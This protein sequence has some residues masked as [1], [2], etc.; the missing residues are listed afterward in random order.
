MSWKKWILVLVAVVLV[1]AWAAVVV[2]HALGVGK[3]AWIALV[4]M[5]AVVT[6]GAFWVVAAVL[7]T[8]VYQARRR[9]LAWAIARLR[10]GS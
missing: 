3:V 7:G 10:G 9:I 6:E 4:T 8:S 5:A 1:A 2:G